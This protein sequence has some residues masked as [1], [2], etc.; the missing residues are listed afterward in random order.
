MGMNAA[1]LKL[2]ESGV[3]TDRQLCNAFSTP[4]VLFNDPANSTYNNYTT[5]LK[6]F[7]TDAVLP[8]SNKVLSDLN[9][10]LLKQYSERDNA[11]YSWQLDT[12]GVEAL[13][14]DQ[15]E[16]AEKD[17]IQTETLNTLM[18]T[19]ITDEAKQLILVTRHGYTEDEA[20]TVVTG[21]TEIQNSRTNRTGGIENG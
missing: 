20:R 13:Q 15:K 21:S 16:E 3:L 14:A 7:Y 17:K 18:A 2:I 19:P 6:S 9:E 5:A 11:E 4:S 1:D 8:V 12:S 10:T